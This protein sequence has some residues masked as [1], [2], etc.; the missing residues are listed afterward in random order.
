MTSTVDQLREAILQR[1][2]LLR[3]LLEEH[4]TTTVYDYITAYLTSRVSVPNRSRQT[5]CIDTIQAVVSE[6]L[7][8]A[9]GASVARQLQR[10]Y[11]VSTGD[12]QVCLGPS[13]AFNSNVLT[14]A[15]YPALHDP[16]LQHVIV[17]GCASV[18]LSH[19]D[20]PR[21]IQLHVRKQPDVVELQRF[22]FFSNKYH[23]RCLYQFTPYTI[24][25]VARLQQQ[26]LP[27]VLL[28]SIQQPHI[29]ASR[30]F[31]E[32]ITKL[33]YCLWQKLQYDY[34]GTFPSFI[35][36]EQEHVV[37]QLL[38]QHHLLADTALSRL[39]FNPNYAAVLQSLQAAMGQYVK[40]GGL[41]SDLFWG[42]TPGKHCRV[43]LRRVANTLVSDDATVH[44]L[45]TPDGLAAALQAGI[46]FPNL[47]LAFLVLSLYYQ[48]NC[49][50][51][52][53]Q[54]HY[55]AAMQQVYNNS[56]L[57]PLPS[58]ANTQQLL[59]GLRILPSSL[60]TDV[61]LYPPEQFWSHYIAQTKQLTINDLIQLAWPDYYQ[62]T[63]GV[64]L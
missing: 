6:R 46:I 19:R 57:D 23:S 47:F 43:P 5:E 56:G 7:G 41:K 63:Y 31:P 59:Y 49:L 4:G 12:H 21:G 3:K 44:V 15:A 28:D 27:K 20:F 62:F 16:L 36:I 37:S 39:L 18:S 17:L 9:I 26:A 60:A 11:F 48:L 50:G 35:E 1:R 24:K 22:G 30:S 40:Q 45:Y 42:I 58:V 13:F 2:P 29:L 38:I 33:N 55:L 32:Q 34:P 8:E 64:P 10:Y 51:G 54:L 14:A 61:I 25:D 53:N 52:F